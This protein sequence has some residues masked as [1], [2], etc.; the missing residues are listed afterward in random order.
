MN[1]GLNIPCYPGTSVPALLQ[2]SAAYEEKNNNGN[3]NDIK[4]DSPETVT[5]EGVENQKIDYDLPAGSGGLGGGS[6]PPGTQII[7]AK[8]SGTPTAPGTYVFYYNNKTVIIVILPA[9][10]GVSFGEIIR[11]MVV[12]GNN[13]LRARR[14]SW[15]VRVGTNIVRIGVWGTEIWGYDSSGVGRLLKAE[16]MA[17]SDLVARDWECFLPGGTLPATEGVSLKTDRAINHEFVNGVYMVNYPEYE[18][19]IVNLFGIKID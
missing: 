6:I 4:E 15:G 3:Y 16:D 13:Q 14:K 17:Y 8:L 1:V 12:S 11:I 2:V 10:I 18:K 19:Y 7:N 9:N 5:G